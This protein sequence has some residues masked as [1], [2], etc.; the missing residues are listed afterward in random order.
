[1]YW[2]ANNLQGWTMSQKI[3]VDN[4]KWDYIKYA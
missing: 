3:P 2:N 4:F 1:M